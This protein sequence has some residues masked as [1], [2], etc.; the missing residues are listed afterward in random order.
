MTTASIMGL[1]TGTTDENYRNTSNISRTK[2]PSL[3]M[4][5]LTL[6]LYLPIP[7]NQGVKSIM[8]M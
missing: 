7:L 1:Q 4:S 3:N 6:Q 5:R 8:K 2:P